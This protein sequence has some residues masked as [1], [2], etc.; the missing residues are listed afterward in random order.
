MAKDRGIDLVVKVKKMKEGWEGAA[1]GHLQ[2]L[3][4]RDS[5]TILKGSTHSLKNLTQNMSQS[6]K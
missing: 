6:K 3:Y 4:E 2:I 1:K 5:L